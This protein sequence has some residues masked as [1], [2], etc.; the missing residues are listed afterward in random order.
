[1]ET[2]HTCQRVYLG[3]KEI[4]CV[5]H[6]KD[7]QYMEVFFPLSFYNVGRCSGHPRDQNEHRRQ[8]NML[9]ESQ[10]HLDSVLASLLTGSVTLGQSLNLE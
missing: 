7:A 2:M 3:R 9:T 5:K 10:T 6:R 1:M 4:A 8:D